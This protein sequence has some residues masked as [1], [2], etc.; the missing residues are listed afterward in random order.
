VGVRVDIQ[1]KIESVRQELNAENQ[2]GALKD[3]SKVADLESQLNSLIEQINPVVVEEV[4]EGAYFLD[5][6]DAGGINIKDLF[7]YHSEDNAAMAYAVVRDIFQSEILKLQGQ[8]R[9]KVD[10]IE[11]E[12]EALKQNEVANQEDYDSL[13]ELLVEKRAEANTLQLNLEDMTHK[14]K[15]AADELEEAKVEIERLNSQI[16]D[17]RTEM[18]LGAKE[19]HKVISVDVI[20]SIENYKKSIKEEEMKKP[21]IYNVRP[22][23]NRNSKFAAN[24]AETDEYLEDHYMYLKGKYREVSADEAPSFRREEPQH[25]DADNIGDIVEE[26]GELRLPFQS[27]ESATD[28]LDEVNANVGMADKTVEERLEALEIAVFGQIRNAA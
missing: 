5:L 15:A 1:A 28:R 23:D 19:A 17:L 9:Y 6:V 8:E 27:E 4:A 16:D 11:K 14:R 22:L 13:Y 20:A 3:S 25:T 7:V 2:R 21:V 10:M 18:E 24:Y 12:L 26:S